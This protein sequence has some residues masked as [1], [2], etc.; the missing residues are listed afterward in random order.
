MELKNKRII[1]RENDESYTHISA[2]IKF[3]RENIEEYRI[4]HL[5][6]NQQKIREKNKEQSKTQKKTRRKIF[7]FK[8]KTHPTLS[9]YNILERLSKTLK[10]TKIHIDYI[11]PHFMSMKIKPTILEQ[12]EKDLESFGWILENNYFHKL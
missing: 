1:L 11:K 2:E 5:S 4:T 10:T 3:I 7:K 8:N 12:I 9:L 6:K